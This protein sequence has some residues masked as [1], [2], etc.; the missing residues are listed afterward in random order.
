MVKHLRGF[1][2]TG[3]GGFPTAATISLKARMFSSRENCLP[4]SL[5]KVCG[6]HYLK[7]ILL[8]KLSRRVCRMVINAETCT[9]LNSSSLAANVSTVK[10]DIKL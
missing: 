3:E 1:G 7:S 10:D 5:N 4:K 2:T 6:I 8:F 9:S